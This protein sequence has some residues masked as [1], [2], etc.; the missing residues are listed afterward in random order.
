MTRLTILALCL[1]ASTAWAKPPS[2][3]TP[4]VDHLGSGVY[5]F[6]FEFATRGGGWRFDDQWTVPFAIPD[7]SILK[8]VQGTVAFRSPRHCSPQ[9]LSK[10]IVG[11]YVFPLIHKLPWHKAERNKV[12]NMWI[13]YDLGD[14]VPVEF[15]DVTFAVD[16]DGAKC[17]NITVEFQGILVTGSAP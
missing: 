2:V 11:S 14:G 13:D 16:V 15:G 6:D 5:R 17:R 9:H 1:V 4:H 3:T 8:S 10:I 12:V 7:G